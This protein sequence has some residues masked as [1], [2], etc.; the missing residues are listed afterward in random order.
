MRYRK[1]A[2]TFFSDR[3][4]QRIG[5]TIK[6]CESRTI[7]EVAVMIVD[8]SDHYPEAEVIGGISLGSL[9]A[10]ILAFSLFHASIWVYIVC[11]FIFFFPSRY[12]FRQFPSLYAGF[13]G[14]ERKEVAV[15]QRAIRAFYEKELYKTRKNTGVLFFLS[16]FER[17]VWVLADKGIYE[18]IEQETL[19]RFADMVSAGIQEGRA[20][21]A[22]CSAIREA[23]DLLEKYF[24]I[25]LGDVNELSDK[26]I[27]E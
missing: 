4:K 13:I 11:S 14:T 24:P 6:D 20:C 22:L 16:L 9:I 5:E 10:L 2:D 26:V 23:G 27:T 18:K 17:K 3:E 12:L 19:K 8:R 21:D 1:N 7:G 15:M 25:T